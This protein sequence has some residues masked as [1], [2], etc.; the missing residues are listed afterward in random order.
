MQK[1]QAH[2]L[3]TLLVFL[4]IVGG[5]LTL[6]IA[7]P[8]AYVRMTYEDLYGEWGQW[9]QYVAVVLLSGWLALR[10]SP[11]RWF[12]VA[13]ALAAFYTAG[14]E[15]SWGQRLFGIV[16]PDFFDEYNLQ[17]ETNLHN[18]LTGP[19]HSRSNDL[20][21]YVVGVAIAGYGLVYP[22][23]LRFGWSLAT[24][25]RGLG[26]PAPPLELAPFFTIAAVL[27]LGLFH[28]NESEVA[29]ILIGCAL[30]FMLAGHAF[31]IRS[32]PVDGPLDASR[33]RRLATLLTLLVLGM[34]VLAVTTTQL[35]SSDPDR[36]AVI[37]QRVLNGFERYGNRFEELGQ[38]RRSA[39]LFTRAYE[40]QR[41]RTDLLV[42]LTA[43]WRMAGDEV[44]YR[45]YYPELLERTVSPHQRWAPNVPQQLSMAYSDRENGDA[46]TAAQHLEF[47]RRLAT[48]ATEQR[49]SDP[50]A[51]YTLGMVYEVMTD[52]GK[53]REQY[54]RAQ[55]LLP[56][57]AKY[58]SGYQRVDAYLHKAP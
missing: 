44:Q 54:G 31:R 58:R 42:K 41:S 49:P 18:F 51:A 21:K 30:L 27:E 11:Y 46:A 10:P 35:D 28:F 23:L 48:Q 47:A 34:V 12:Y 43:N 22:L 14:E 17:G 26:I 53:A 36:R 37:E 1:P 15:I 45:R 20:M 33:S 52:Y 4:L 57:E 24:W 32:G 3:T 19:V 50:E 38:W 39:D 7:W 5:Y 9:C 16:S 25:V 13:L 6:L 56:S 29:E 2:Q 8:S 55:T 40:A